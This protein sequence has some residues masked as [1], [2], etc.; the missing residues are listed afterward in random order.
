MCE[1]SAI[2]LPNHFLHSRCPDLVDPCSLIAA[3]SCPCVLSVSTSTSEFAFQNL[4]LLFLCCIRVHILPD[5]N[6]L[7]VFCNQMIFLPVHVLEVSK[8]H[9]QQWI[10]SSIL[11][12]LTASPPALR[13]STELLPLHHQ[14][15]TGLFSLPH[16]FLWS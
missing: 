4:F 8:F 2:H 3:L 13:C 16:F 6:N 9:A 1:A 14:K 12:G 5:T 7:L 15:K 11:C 10:D